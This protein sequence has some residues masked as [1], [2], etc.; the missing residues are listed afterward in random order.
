MWIR[1]SP[2]SYIKLFCMNN[3]YKPQCVPAP[4][5]IT[6]KTYG[7]EKS[8]YFPDVPP[9]T[10]GSVITFKLNLHECKGLKSLKRS[11]WLSI[12]LVEWTDQTA[13]KQLYGEATLN[14][15]KCL[16]TF[17]E[18]QQFLIFG[19]PGCGLPV[20]SEFDT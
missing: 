19:G 12:N 5:I 6:M 10:N 9:C 20:V 18:N 15:I 2:N 16:Q 7:S 4:Y 3:L 17:C 13:A 8:P 14:R 1:F 11:K